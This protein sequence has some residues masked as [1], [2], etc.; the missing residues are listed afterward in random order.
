MRH[1]FRNQTASIILIYVQRFG[2]YEFS[3]GPLQ[4]EILVKQAPLIKNDGRYICHSRCF[5][6]RG[7]RGG[8]AFKLA[9][10]L[11]VELGYVF[12]GLRL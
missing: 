2:R 1:T 4:F 6:I 8:G 10:G 5:G 12:L 9:V 7:G 3:K 11:S